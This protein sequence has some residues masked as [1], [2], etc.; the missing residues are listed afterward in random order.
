MLNWWT[1]SLHLVVLRFDFHH[2]SNEGK[3]VTEAEWTNVL[4]FCC[5][6]LI[7]CCVVVLFLILLCFGDVFRYFCCVLTLLCLLFCACVFD[8]VADFLFS[9]FVD[10]FFCF[11]VEFRF[12]CSVLILLCLSFCF[13]VLILLF[14]FE[15]L[16]LCLLALAHFPM[17]CSLTVHTAV[18]P[19]CPDVTGL[20]S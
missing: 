13:C 14:S 2:H 5:A 1:S 7:Y 12:F 9:C 3:A 11:A 18:M 15:L 6:F 4:F 17:S 19:L 10:F 8:F 20:Y 16:S